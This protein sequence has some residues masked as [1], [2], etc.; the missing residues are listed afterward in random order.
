MTS[1]EILKSVFGY[2]EFRSGQKEIIDEILAKKDCLGI[3]PTGAGKSICYQVPALQL[4]GITIVISPLI[5]L[6]KD[7]V[8]ALNQAGIHAAYINSSLTERQIS[9]AFDNA[10]RGQ[11]KIIY[12]A[13]ERLDTKR[14][15]ELI[16]A[17]D[18]SMVAVDEAHCI[19]QWG[20]D[21]RPAY[22]NIVK[23][24]NMLERRPV[25]AAFTA[26]ATKEVKEDIIKILGLNNPQVFITSFDRPNLYFRVKHVTSKPVEALRYC[27]EHR[28]ECGIVYCATRKNVEEICD[29]LN[30]KGIPATRYHAGLT[31]KERSKNQ[32]DFI[33]DRVKVVVATN[34]FG[35]GIDKSDVRYVLH[36]N[37]PQSMENYYQEAGRAGRDG[38]ESECL[39]LYNPQ[40][41]II[42]RF[43]IENKEAK[44]DIDIETQKEIARRDSKRLQVMIDY[45]NTTA[46]L[47]TF[48][49]QYFGEQADYKD[50]RANSMTACGH[51]CNCCNEVDFVDVTNEASK[52]VDCVY[53]LGERFGQGM[54]ISVL[55]GDDNDR[56]IRMGLNELSSFASLAS[57]SE[58]SLKDIINELIRQEVLVKTT[59]QYPLLQMGPRRKVFDNGDIKISIRDEGKDS[60]FKRELTRSRKRSLSS[61][62]ESDFSGGRAGSSY[63]AFGAGYGSSSYGYSDYGDDYS[64]GSAG[65]KGRKRGPAGISRDYYTSAS[66]INLSP[67]AEELLANLKQVRKSIAA[68]EKMPAYIIFGDKT[69]MQMCIYRPTSYEEMLGISG[70]GENKN[71]KY[72][73]E[74]AREIAKFDGK[75]IDDSDWD[76]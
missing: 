35:M 76:L 10:C 44:D 53:E 23:F 34:A 52:L 49:L 26:T 40:D 13:P 33:Y 15:F 65:A 19:S 18:I 74:F 32:D 46:C 63:G 51:C 11:Y 3:M 75:K 12:I 21:F 6:M 1:N 39:L 70:V 55:R 37:M 7:Q 47:R 28:D 2:E 68:R 4:P 24:V 17:V 25:I 14:F 64:Y 69:L 9:M 67:E 29:L 54:V 36:Y 41:I 22:L 42:N 62:S 58:R 30:S 56:I 20:Q 66:K 60:S 43:L 45:C 61:M 16:H 50:S 5:S 71:K 48:I 73:L 27:S 59:G 57:L 31:N 38:E 72:G 8:F